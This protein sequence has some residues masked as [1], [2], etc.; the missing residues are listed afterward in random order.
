VG[1]DIKNLHV[2]GMVLERRG[3][4]RCLLV[5]LD[6][7]GRA[8]LF[9]GSGFED[10]ARTMLGLLT[11]ELFDESGQT[12]GLLAMPEESGADGTSHAK[13][14]TPDRY[15]PH[16]VPQVFYEERYRSG[17]GS[18][19][20]VVYVVPED[21]WE[22]LDAPEDRGE[23]AAGSIRAVALG[24]LRARCLGGEEPDMGAFEELVEG[25][26][27]LVGERDGFREWE[28]E[29]DHNQR[30]RRAYSAFM[31]HVLPHIGEGS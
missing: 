31:T 24:D 25:G 13:G 27:E 5:P 7:S 28:P 19:Y 15:A 2:F 22:R 11:K 14:W 30:S 1:D 12:I 16:G 3:E 4:E 9:G 23:D 17:G 26:E 8:T 10:D 18:K 20:G 29:D 6:E 21:A